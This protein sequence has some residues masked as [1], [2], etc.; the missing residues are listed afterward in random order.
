MD[1][2]AILRKLRELLNEDSTSDY[3]DDRTSYEYVYQAAI[4][5]VDRTDS[6]TTTQTITTVA[7]QQAYTLNADYLKMYLKNKDN[8]FYLKYNDGTAD[9]M[10]VFKDKEDIIFQN[11]TA[12]TTI[13]AG[14]YI[15]DDPNLDSASTGANATTS[16]GLGGKSFV[17]HASAFADVSAGDNIHNITDASDGY[18]LTEDA[19]TKLGTALF[20]GTNDY[21][22]AADDFIVQPQGRS[23][24]VMTPPPSTSAHT[25]TFYYVQR[26]APVFN[27]YGMY[28]FPTQHMTAIIFYAAWLYK[29]R[30]RAPGFGD[31]YFQFWENT[32]AKASRSHNQSYNKRGWKM[33]LR[34]RP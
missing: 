19:S 30:D 3:M 4:E 26:P 8:N 31:R 7:D 24:I 2:K 11:S 23:R 14:W 16:T 18:I 28:R 13:P 17:A 1:G 22:T 34:K 29:Y 5:F 20:G 21:W 9:Q 33:N 27:D 10:L 6:L 25:I 12:S 32:V 15:E